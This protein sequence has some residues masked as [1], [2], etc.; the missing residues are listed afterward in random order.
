MKELTLRYRPFLLIRFYRTISVNYP[1][2]WAEINASQLVAIACLYNQ[3]LTDV[4]FISKMFA[5]PKKIVRRF[6]PFELFKIM[7][8][9]EFIADRKPFH[10]FIIKELPISSVFGLHASGSLLFAPLPK[11]KGVTFG[12][13][14][15][16]DTY[17]AD[18]Q[19]TQKQ[20]DLHKFIAALYLKKGEIFRESVIERHSLI[21][22][23]DRH[24]LE[25]IYINY[26]LLREWLALAYPLI[27]Q[28]HDSRDKAHSESHPELVSGSVQNTWIK[29]FQNIVGDDILH[30]DQWADKPINTIF[31]FMTRKYKE[32]ARK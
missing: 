19:R 25:A 13:F 8:C 7:Q 11:L 1:E 17:F 3:A 10:E 24:T 22:R 21:N 15:F 26:N 31:Q 18:Y 28:H 27:F 14:I 12:Q 16:A 20:E 5:L 6:A 9:I 2:S 29:V 4:Q 23:I 32:N 30:D